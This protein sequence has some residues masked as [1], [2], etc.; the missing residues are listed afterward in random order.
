ME[1]VQIAAMVVRTEKKS[2]FYVDSL[3]RRSTYCCYS[4][5][6]TEED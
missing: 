1:T 2:P 5:I 6:P 4:K 3:Q